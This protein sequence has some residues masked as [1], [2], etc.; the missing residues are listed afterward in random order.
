[1]EANDAV[2]AVIPV[3]PSHPATACTAPVPL[4]CTLAENRMSRVDKKVRLF[5]LAKVQWSAIVRPP[6]PVAATV[7][8]P[9][10]RLAMNFVMKSAFG[11]TAALEPTENASVPVENSTS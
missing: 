1:M 8:R 9:P 11:E 6:D 3:L 2:P 7:T 5:E 10:L 4:F